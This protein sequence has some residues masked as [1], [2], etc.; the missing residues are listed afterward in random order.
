MPDPAALSQDLAKVHITPTGV[1]K[2]EAQ[3]D[4][5]HFKQKYKAYKVFVYTCNEC[6]L[7]TLLHLKRCAQCKAKNIYY[8]STLQVSE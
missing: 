8:D 2:S 7:F 1:N 3:Q 4:F 5:Y 6:S